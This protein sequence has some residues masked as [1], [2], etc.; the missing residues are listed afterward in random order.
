MNASRKFWY[1]ENFNLFKSLDKK[2]LMSLS[3]LVSDQILSKNDSINFD[4]NNSSFIYF[5]KDGK[6]KLS[7]LSAGGKEMIISLLHPGE[8]FGEMAIFNELSNH[9]YAVAI[10]DCIVCSIESNTFKQL[11]ETNPKLN[12]EVTKLIGLRLKK[13]SK[14]I[15]ELFFLD[16]KQ[17]VISFLLN[18]AE[19]FGETVGVE[20]FVKPFLTHQNIAE[21]TA[22]SRQ[23]VNSILTDLRDKNIIYFDRKKLI[24][25]D[26]SFLETELKTQ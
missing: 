14:R 12:L 20:I 5:L 6:L 9:D 22:C 15:E 26:K 21:L 7:R 1:L 19:D 25:R 3:K 10:E 8:I 18:F 4:L 23:T 2:T 11:M 17:R 16:A 13:F 24:I